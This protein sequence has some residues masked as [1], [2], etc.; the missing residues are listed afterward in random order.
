MPLNTWKREATTTSTPP[1][2]SYIRPEPWCCVTACPSRPE[3]LPHNHMVQCACEVLSGPCGAGAPRSEITLLRFNPTGL[4]ML[5]YIDR[6]TASQGYLLTPENP[7]E[8]PPAP[9]RTEPSEMSSH[10]VTLTK[11][12]YGNVV[13]VMRITATGLRL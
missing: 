10:R 7:P 6:Y 8:N 1:L 5:T 2:S 13:I 9:C 3:L 4:K 11:G 12:G